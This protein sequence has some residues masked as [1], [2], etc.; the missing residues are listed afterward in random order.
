MMGD[1]YVSWK[2]MNNYPKITPFYS[3]LSGALNIAQFL[4]AEDEC[5]CVSR[6]TD[7]LH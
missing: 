1:K 2:N 4:V 5:D 3:F 6:R 7:A